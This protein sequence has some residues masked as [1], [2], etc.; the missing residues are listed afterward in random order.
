MYYEKIMKAFETIFN[1]W[2]EKNY[3]GHN[4]KFCYVKD[5]NK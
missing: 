4:F 3:S 2:N 1:A 5:R